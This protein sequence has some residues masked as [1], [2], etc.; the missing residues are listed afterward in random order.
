MNFIYRENDGS[1]SSEVATS[2][3]DDD[4]IFLGDVAEKLHEFL[5]AVGY[6]VIDVVFV[7]GNGATVSSLD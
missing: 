2:A 4:Q 5:D 6:D 7:L 1:T 3:R